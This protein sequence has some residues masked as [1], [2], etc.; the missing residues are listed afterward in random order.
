[1]MHSDI[2]NHDQTWPSFAG[3]ILQLLSESSY[4]NWSHTDWYGAPMAAPPIKK[5]TRP[6]ADKKTV[7]TRAKPKAPAAPEHHYDDVDSILDEIEMDWD[8]TM[9]A[10]LPPCPEHHQRPR[11]EIAMAVARIARRFPTPQALADTFGQPGHIAFLRCPADHSVELMTKILRA[12]FANTV[13]SPGLH[14]PDARRVSEVFDSSRPAKS[15]DRSGM[16][17][18]FWSLIEDGRP[19]ILVGPNPSKLP[20]V[21]QDSVDTEIILPDLDREMLRV[22]FGHLYPGQTVEPADIPASLKDSNIAA[23]TPARLTMAARAGS[24]RAAG[25]R[26]AAAGAVQRKTGPGLAEF[27]LSD[28]VRAPVEQVLADLRDWQAGRIKWA[29]VTCGLLLEGPPGCG[30]TE[31]PKL[32]ARD[33]GFPVF[34]ASLSRWQS[35]GERSSDLLQKM[36]AFFDKAMQASPAIVFIDELDAIGDRNRPHDQSSSWTASIVA[37]LL[38]CLDGFDGREGIVVIAATNYADKIDAALIRPGR[39]DHQIRMEHPTPDLLPTA[40]RYHLVDDLREADLTGVCAK[41]TGLSGAQVA[42]AVKAARAAARR[43]RRALHP[44]DLIR[45]VEHLRPPIAPEMAWAVAVHESGHA[46]VAHATGRARPKLLTIYDG[47]GHAVMIPQPNALRRSDIEAEI[48]FFLAGRAAERLVLGR[49]SGGAGGRE[50]CDLA[51]ATQRATGL[52]MSYGLGDSG[53]VWVGPPG[54]AADR[55]RFDAGLREKAQGHLTR[56]EAMAS[57]ILI[58][59]RATL[60]SEHVF[61]LTGERSEEERSTGLSIVI[62]PWLCTYI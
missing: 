56:A 58:E 54:D 52:E 25:G 49:P 55:L 8:K 36:R 45:S 62:S 61:K 39:F 32:L 14:R 27:P 42:Q 22:V 33:A 15:T 11:A 57:A 40:F 47:G 13:L 50:G 7:G 48:A 34:A 16:S 17:E 43:A 4:E 2:E 35:E 37:G 38:E 59:N 44:D 46:I 30:K 31:L 5:A 41:A 10:V 12:L 53:T 6:S 19:L 18:G 60:S 24:P 1:M 3:Q 26:L 21:L 23:L 20:T 28:D 9:G 51:Q 29:D